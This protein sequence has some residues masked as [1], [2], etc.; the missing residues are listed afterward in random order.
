VV[1]FPGV[2][3]N[4]RRPALIISSGEYHQSRPDVIVGLIT[5][6]LPSPRGITDHILVDW[7]AAGLN[8]PSAFRAFLVTM[9]RTAITSAIGRV[10]ASDWTAIQACV[11]AALAT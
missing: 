5:S 11:R 1:D 3:G 2:Q 10:S 6:Q 9:P 4:K 7:N 8:K